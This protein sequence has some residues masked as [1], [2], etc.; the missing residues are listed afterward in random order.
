[1]VLFDAHRVGKHELDYPAH[2]DGRR[3]L[4]GWKMEE[5]GW[6]PDGQGR[7]FDPA[8]VEK[9]REAFRSAA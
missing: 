4:V 1:V 9:A 8:R 6:T 7:W 3:C 2:G 5:Q